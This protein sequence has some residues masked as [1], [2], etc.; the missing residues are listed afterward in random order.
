M[1]PCRVPSRRP[2]LTRGSWNNLV[3]YD[4][5]AAA[6][7]LQPHTSLHPCACG[8]QV[9][10]LLHLQAQQAE[11]DRHALAQQM[12]S[13]T[14]AAARLERAAARLE[15]EELQLQLDAYKEPWTY[16]FRWGLGAAAQCVWR[17]AGSRM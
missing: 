7:A 11:Q 14:A 3:A 2:S 15:V 4:C 10:A 9:A 17:V 6:D 8:M 12:A 1:A 5:P 16:M 13:N